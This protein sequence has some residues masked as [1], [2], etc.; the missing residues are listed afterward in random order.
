MRFGFVSTL[1]SN[2]WGGSE[3]LWSSSA[4]TLA[5]SG[6]EV[7][8]A[9]PK[10]PSRA[11][12]VNRLQ[13][14]FGIDVWEYAITQ[15]FVK[16]ILGKLSA[17]S[18]A[19]FSINNMVSWL[20]R[21]KPDLLCISSGNA[22]DGSDWMKLAHNEGVPYVHI[23]QA[24]VEFLWP[25]DNEI[26]VL[27]EL[28]RAAQRCF[29]VSRGNLSLFETQLAQVLDNAEVVR[30]P[31]NVSWDSDLAWPPT[32]DGVWRLACVGR[33]HPSSKGQDLLLGVL[34][35][36]E[37]KDR[38]FQLSF[39]GEGP[40][41]QMLRRLVSSYGLDEKVIFRGQIQNVEQIWHDN[42][43]LV[44]PSRY[45]GLPLAVVEA[46]LC[47]RPVIVTDVAGN[48]EVVDDGVTGFIAEAPTL[49]HLAATMEKAWSARD[50][51]QSMGQRAR[52]EIRQLVPKDAAAV[53]AAK[54]LDIAEPCN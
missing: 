27:R 38:P 43:A 39:Y 5:M 29:F 20:R 37:W 46:L 3:M 30:N 8:A 47:G 45:E 33:L 18:P 44:L 24:H 1:A 26:D 36:T 50:Q 2:P 16:R 15:S 35:R 40:Q 14:E 54:L 12:A 25:A 4:Q 48:S 42:H 23:A 10:W 13:A 17:R 21:T 51:W 49:S 28:Y 41:G 22:V 32:T 52:Q 19:T 7:F 34:R 11:P 31:V 53:F 9:V 6:H